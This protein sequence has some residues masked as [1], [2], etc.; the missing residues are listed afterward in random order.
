[1]GAP[2]PHKATPWVGKGAP[3]GA[4]RPLALEVP[5]SLKMAQPGLLDT[6]CSSGPSSHN[7]W[8]RPLSTHRLSPTPVLT[9]FP[10]GHSSDRARHSHLSQHTP[11][12]TGRG[13]GKGKQH[14]ASVNKPT[15]SVWGKG[16]ISV[17]P[18]LYAQ[19]RSDCELENLLWQQA[20]ADVYN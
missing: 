16:V 4:G 9:C 8:P 20:G 11:A 18:V 5:G 15:L 17:C 10:W 2:W 19:L 7:L 14:V 12:C 6:P 3:A 13:P 1:M